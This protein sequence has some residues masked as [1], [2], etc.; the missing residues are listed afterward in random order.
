MNIDF[1]TVPEFTTGQPISAYDLNSLLHNNV[2]AQNILYSPQPLFMDS[3][4][5]AP[6]AMPMIWASEEYDIWRGSFMYRSGMRYAYIG[7]HTKLENSTADLNNE[8]SISKFTDISIAVIVKYTNLTYKQIYT[9]N[10]LKKNCA[11]VTLS[12]VGNTTV[13]STGGN[14]VFVIKDGHYNSAQTQ[15][16]LGT[17][18]ITRGSRESSIRIDLSP[19]GLQDTEIVEVKLVLVTH[20][21]PTIAANLGEGY[22]TFFN[23]FLRKA[24]LSG[25]VISKSHIYYATLYAKTD[26]DLSYTANWPTTQFTSTGNSVLSANNLKIITNKQKYITERLRNRPMPLTG[27]I[28]YIGAFG[29]TSSVRLHQEDVVPGEW[30][31]YEANYWLPI[32]NRLTRLDKNKDQKTV[33]DMNY[34]L[35]SQSNLATFSWS[36]YFEEYDSVYLNFRFFGNTESR[37]AIFLDMPDQPVSQVSTRRSILYWPSAA[38]RLSSHIFGNYSGQNLYGS[39]FTK[40]NTIAGVFNSSA[41]KTY[42]NKMYNV[43]IPSPTTPVYSPQF[44]VN[45]NNHTATYSKFYFTAG[46]WEDSVG[47][48]FEKTA[49]SGAVQKWGLVK[50]DVDNETIQYGFIGDASKTDA[51]TGFVNKIV[52]SSAETEVDMQYTQIPQYNDD[53]YKW[54]TVN[55]SKGYAPIFVNVY[56]NHSRNTQSKA[57]Y[58]SYTQV[59]GMSAYNPDNRMYDPPIVYTPQDTVTYS[60]LCSILSEI[61]TKL[62]SLRESMFINNPH[63]TQYDFFWGAPISLLSRAGLF[64]EYNDKF[65]FF[66]KQRVGNIL[67]VRGKNITLHYGEIDDLKRD[68]DPQGSLHPIGDVGI[69]FAKTES[70]ISGDAE[71]TVVV[72]LNNIEELAYGQYYFLNGE[73]IIYAS[74]FYEEPS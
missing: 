67:I 58:I 16:L 46:M 52:V 47:I 54:V 7:F 8:F 36:P 25:P 15:T 64:K 31:Y 72:H 35:N 43:R 5:Y 14:Y 68:D 62:D 17:Q 24:K 45:S 1:Q 55:G 20:S 6:K 65:F 32:D 37:Q 28:T 13:T 40:H 48:R 42:L 30:D 49:E 69:T 34:S 12:Q 39:V 23:K 59:L 27:S 73:S 9:N 70:I 63:F 60:G 21:D 66:A 29:G 50:S 56:D 51:M 4:A 33:L 18:V 11:A 44:N 53:D 2:T 57:N 71:Q 61:D 38:G 19:L 3:H 10:S 26:G 41:P 74:E 22:T